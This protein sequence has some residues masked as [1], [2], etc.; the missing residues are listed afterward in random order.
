MDRRGCSGQAIRPLRGLGV[1]VFRNILFFDFS[2]VCVFDCGCC[3]CVYAFAC[4][5]VFMCVCLYACMCSYVDVCVF[6]NLQ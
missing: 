1:L 6:K 4:A 5:R 3:V 2:C